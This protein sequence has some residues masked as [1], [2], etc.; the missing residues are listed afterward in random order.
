MIKILITEFL[1]KEAL[2]NLHQDFNI[3]YRSESWSD[4]DYL[5]NEIHN[6]DGIIVRNKTKLDKFLLEKALKLKFIGRLGVGL[7]NIDTEYCKNNNIFVQPAT[8]MNADSV[9]EYV[10]NSSL[11]LLKK[12]TIVN[13]QTQNGKWPRTTINTMEMSGKTLGLIGFGNISKKVLKLANAFDVSTITFDPYVSL[14][15][16]NSHNVRRVSFEEILNFADIIS[17]HVPLNNETKYMFNN[18][19]FIKMKKKPIIINSSRGGV[20]NETD[21]L[22]AYFNNNI[23]GFALDVF[24]SEPVNETF[25]SNITNE[26][27]CILTPHNAGVTEESNERVSKFI[28]KKTNDD[29]VFLDP[30]GSLGDEFAIYGDTNY[31]FSKVY[32]SL[33]GYENI[34]L[35]KKIDYDYLKDLKNHFEDLLITNKKIDNISTIKFLTSSLYFSLIKFHSK[36]Y[37]NKFL[38]ISRNL[39]K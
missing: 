7:D 5:E 34:I 1:N 8:G 32:Q 14:E 15:E 24:E 37:T 2:K 27:N 21:L 35:D 28:I 10:I 30:R 25:L 17:I 4:K 20:I 9:A 23:S 3:T 12:T 31:D 16:T 26:M 18:E 33:N 19:S 36:K 22:N 6:F 39:I 29:L 11:T 38:D 13:A